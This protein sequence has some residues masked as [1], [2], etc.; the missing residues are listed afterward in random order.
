MTIQQVNGV[1]LPSSIALMPLY[2]VVHMCCRKS[3]GDVCRL[4]LPRKNVCSVGP[5]C[6]RAVHRVIRVY[7]GT[8]LL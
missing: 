1:R 6:R 8:V 3:R 5:G 2:T 4:L 7:T